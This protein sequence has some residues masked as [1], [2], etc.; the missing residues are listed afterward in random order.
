MSDLQAKDIVNTKN[1]AKIGKICDIVVNETGEILY[2]VV[3]PLKFS[4][5]S[6]RYIVSPPSLYI[7]SNILTGSCKDSR[8]SL[9][10]YSSMWRPI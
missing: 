8:A 1:G 6:K 10:S 2:L 3:E 9:I 7:G 4:T 5:W